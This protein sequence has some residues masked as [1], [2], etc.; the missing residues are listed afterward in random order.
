MT[1]D[2]Q[3]AM[4]LPQRIASLKE[5]LNQYER[6]AIIRREAEANATAAAKENPMAVLKSAL[7]QSLVPEKNGADMLKKQ[8]ATLDTLFDHVVQDYANKK[9]GVGGYNQTDRLDLILR[10]QSRCASTART[11][12]SMDYMKSLQ[13]CAAP[14][15]RDLSLGG[16]PHPPQN[17]EQ[18]EGM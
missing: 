11:L 13:A 12:S 2:D 6:D 9:H 3:T 18:T 8:M 5:N 15:M 4:M 14:A 7:A 16:T 1:D 17:D 10:L